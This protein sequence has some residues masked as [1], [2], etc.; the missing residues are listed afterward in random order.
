MAEKLMHILIDYNQII[1][2][3]DYNVGLKIKTLNLMN[4]PI[5]NLHS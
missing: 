2:S 5:K 3:L 4:Q 1:P